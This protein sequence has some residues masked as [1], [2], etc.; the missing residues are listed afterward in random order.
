MRGCFAVHVQS[1][2]FLP[3]SFAYS[4]RVICEHHKNDTW[5]LHALDA[6][7]KRLKCSTIYSE[8]LQ[9]MPFA[10]PHVFN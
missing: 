2:G 8:C 5:E 10:I 9:G 7:V 4:V 3:L 6:G 1:R